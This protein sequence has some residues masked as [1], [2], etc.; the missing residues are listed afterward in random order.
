MGLDRAQARCSLVGQRLADSLAD[1]RRTVRALALLPLGNA[2]RLAWRRASHP[3]RDATE[4]AAGRRPCHV[5]L[6]VPRAGGTLL[7]RSALPLGVPRAV[8]PGDRRS[9]SAALRH[10]ACSGDRDSAALASRLPAS[11]RPQ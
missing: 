5:L 11:R 3:P 2:T 9:A 6:P 8:G 10:V 4:S 7:R 1:P